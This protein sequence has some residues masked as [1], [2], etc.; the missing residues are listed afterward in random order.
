MSEKLPSTYLE[1]REAIEE[2]FDCIQGEPRGETH[3]PPASSAVPDV[4][5][6]YRYATLGYRMPRARRELPLVRLL[7]EDMQIVNDWCAELEPGKR[8]RLLWRRYPR[9]ENVVR[10]ARWTV[11]SMR[12]AVP[13]VNE[14]LVMLRGYKIDGTPYVIAPA[15]A[16]ARYLLTR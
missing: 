13:L 15:H 14:R 12:L 5:P 11:V 9:V 2:L 16:T 8:P 6:T 3:D 7:W 4:G 1:L 10:E